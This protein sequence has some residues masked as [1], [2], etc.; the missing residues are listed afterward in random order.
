[1]TSVPYSGLS[2]SISL[3]A[4]SGPLGAIAQVSAVTAAGAEDGAVLRAALA[5]TSDG[6]GASGTG[7]LASGGTAAA[8]SSG[9]RAEAATARRVAR[10]KGRIGDMTRALTRLTGSLP[11]A[12]A[13]VSV[14]TGAGRD[15]LSVWTQ[16]AVR[17]IRTGAGDDTVAIGAATVQGVATGSGSDA[18]SIVAR[19]VEGIYTGAQTGPRTGQRGAMAEAD[20]DA[21]AIQ[22]EAVDSIYTGAGR[23]AVA[24]NAGL[25]QSV[26]TGSGA[27]SLAISA[28]ALTGIYSGDGDDVVTIRA[29]TGASRGYA[30][31]AGALLAEG[32]ASRMQAVQ[33]PEADVNLGEGNDV[34]TLEVAEMASVNAGRGDD[35]I[36]FSGGTLGLLYAAGDGRDVVSLAA[37]STVAIQLRDIDSWTATWEGETLI[38]GFG[39]GQIRFEGAAGAAAIGITGFG[40]A[41]PVMLHL[42]EGAALD[43]TV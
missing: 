28:G 21:L 22:A 37:G 19:R 6:A 39:S 29:V 7:A 2:S 41:E 11:E 43:L 8:A 34:L 1:M 23:D 24:I 14:R 40:Q 9:A 3:L 27:D 35:V 18:V 10:I 33:T 38:L 12:E 4:A 32:A 36:G 20:D 30:A 15:L 42:S 25:V 13:A 17:D 26:Y 16:G 31:S 5:E